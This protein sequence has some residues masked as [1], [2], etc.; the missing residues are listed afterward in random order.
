[1]PR[2]TMFLIIFLAVAAGFFLF[3]AFSEVI[4]PKKHVS[5]STTAS[6]NQP[7]SLMIIK[8][9]LS[10]TTG[11]SSATLKNTYHQTLNVVLDTPN[12]IRTLQLDLSYDPTSINHVKIAKGQFLSEGTELF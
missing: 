7:T 2:K 8:D 1:M 6:L 12:S 4:Q 10:L 3:L 9:S 5:P 11:S